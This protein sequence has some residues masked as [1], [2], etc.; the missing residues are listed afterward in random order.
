MDRRSSVCFS[1]NGNRSQPVTN[2][3]PVKAGVGCGIV[4]MTLTVFLSFAFLATL[5]GFLLNDFRFV[6]AGLP[7]SAIFTS[8]GSDFI[9][10]YPVDGVFWVGM[11]FIVAKRT[12][13]KSRKTWLMITLGI[14]AAMTIFGAALGNFVTPTGIF[15]R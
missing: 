12:E 15:F 4:T 3:P 14:M 10:A 8:L 6:F 7:T 13:Q 1:T 2:E 11:A 9:L 5:T